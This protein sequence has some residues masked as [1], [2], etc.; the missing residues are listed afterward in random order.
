MFRQL[1]A[2][3]LLT[4]TTLN[5]TP[6]MAIA[7]TDKLKIKNNTVGV[8][9][10]YLKET[11]NQFLTDFKIT[12]TRNNKKVVEKVEL[13]YKQLP[14][15][16]PEYDKKFYGISEDVK[17]IDL[18]GNGEAEVVVDIQTPG[19]HCCSTTFIY[20]Y[21]PQKRSYNVT[22]HYWGNYISSYNTSGISG[23]NNQNQNNYKNL[24]DLN[25]DGIPEFLARDDRFSGEFSP[26]SASFAPVQ[27]WSFQQGKLIDVTERFPKLISQNANDLWAIYRKVR[28]ESGPEPA[29]GAM[30]AYIGA[31]Y[32][33]GQG[34]DGIK[35]LS[36]QYPDKRG[37]NFTK[38][39]R[40]FL[41]KT[42]Y[43]R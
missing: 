13:P 10:G 30:A 35:R 19:T 37:K 22:S 9:V 26:Y 3:G 33:L 31:K 6:V 18:D 29:K 20:S 28:L 42:G 27:V 12:I 43:L 8:E 24:V 34:G 1:L 23:K 36:T 14:N 7:S 39:L 11:Q 40:V 25:S 17:V 21:N 5:L 2:S 32:L 41:Q 15:Y 4:I 38:E 16:D